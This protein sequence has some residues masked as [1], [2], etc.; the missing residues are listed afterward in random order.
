MLTQQDLIADAIAHRRE[1]EFVY[2]GLRRVVIPAALGYSQLGKLALRGYQVA[3]ESRSGLAHGHQWRLYS[4][5][6]IQGLYV[7]EEHFA[8]APPG[9]RRSDSQLRTILA[10]L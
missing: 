7:T 6:K 9:Y 8:D 5:D 10:Q 2:D 3:G 1:V 4:V